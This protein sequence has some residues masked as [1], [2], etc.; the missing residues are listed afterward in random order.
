M[1]DLFAEAP[2]QERME[3]DALDLAHRAVPNFYE[4][5]ARRKLN[6]PEAWRWHGLEVIAGD[7]LVTGAVPVG[8]KRN[9]DPK[10][11]PRA[12]NQRA[13]VTQAEYESARDAWTAET[14]TCWNCAGTM[15][16][17][18]GWSAKDGSRFRPCRFC[19][20]LEARDAE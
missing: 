9:G 11:P 18:A 17:R 1:S 19:T 4:T 8:F 15:F 10:W 7:T 13:I 14:G 20:K 16:E 5:V 2:T 6:V 12:Q 3:R